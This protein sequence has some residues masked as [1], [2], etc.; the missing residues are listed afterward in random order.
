MREGPEGGGREGVRE[1]G[2]EGGRGSGVTSTEVYMQPTQQ[3]CVKPWRQYS[4]R[5][6]KL[7]VVVH[8]T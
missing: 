1:G 3:Y 4:N 5:N 7:H 8:S 6:S 2:S